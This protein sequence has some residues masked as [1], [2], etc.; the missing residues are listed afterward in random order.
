M[1]G[2]GSSRRLCETHGE[3]DS[4]QTKAFSWFALNPDS[5]LNSTQFHV[6]LSPIHC[7]KCLSQNNFCDRFRF[8][9]ETP[10]KLSHLLSRRLF[11]DTR[12]SKVFS[13]QIMAR[14]FG[15]SLILKFSLQ[16]PYCFSLWKFA[17]IADD[18]REFGECMLGIGK[19]AYRNPIRMQAENWTDWCR[20]S[21]S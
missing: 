14:A 4:K 5:T 13:W 17:A 10:R 7:P 3:R 2:T 16:L 19:P 12:F 11:L 9:C 1:N 18:D 6:V 8:S 20:A 15:S 21:R